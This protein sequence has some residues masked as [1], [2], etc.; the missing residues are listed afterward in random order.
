MLFIQRGAGK[1]KGCLYLCCTALRPRLLPPARGALVLRRR[2]P[3]HVPIQAVGAGAADGAA[4]V[5]EHECARVH[6]DLRLLLGVL[7]LAARVQ[8]L[9]WKPESV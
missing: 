1:R 6:A 5:V 4:L 8:I 3:R 7:A 9:Q 2:V